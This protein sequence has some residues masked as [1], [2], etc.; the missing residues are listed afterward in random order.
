[1]PMI[2]VTCKSAAEA[3]S[4]VDAVRRILPKQTAEI[5]DAVVEFCQ[6]EIFL[7]GRPVTRHRIASGLATNRSESVHILGNG[8]QGYNYA[9]R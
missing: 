8:S 1:M 3:R 2:V 7:D 5:A 9:H 6:N 4:A